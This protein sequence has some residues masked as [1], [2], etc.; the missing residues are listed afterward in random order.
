MNIYERICENREKIASVYD[1]ASINYDF[2]R[3]K[4][5]NQALF[6]GKYIEY[7][8]AAKENNPNIPRLRKFTY[9]ICQLFLQ[10]DRRYFWNE[11]LGKTLDEIESVKEKM[12]PYGT[13]TY[14]EA[15]IAYHLLQA[16]DL[17]AENMGEGSLSA[18]LNTQYNKNSFVY[19]C[20][21]KGILADAARELGFRHKIQ[22]TEIRNEFKYLRILEREELDAGMNPPRS[23][24]LYIDQFDSVRQSVLCGKKLKIVMIPF[25]QEELVT[26]E[27]TQGS[28]FRV[29]YIEEHKQ[30]TI[31]R[32]LQMLGEA[33]GQKANIVIFP[34]YVCFPEMQ[35]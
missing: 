19:C 10:K 35:S 21:G 30:N 23:V 26:F 16:V 32:A 6:L 34:E 28:L 5:D 25:G 20:N 2:L 33:I 11:I 15:A 9:E 14:N 17:Y 22:I 13:E 29:K 31:R 18:P 7:S 24:T 1:L 12:E 3:E 8:D 4:I 27:K